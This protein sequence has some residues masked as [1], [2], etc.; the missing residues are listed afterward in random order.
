MIIP[1]QSVNP[2]TLEAIIESFVLREGTD[3][4]EQEKS[5]P[6]KVD[7]VKRRLKNGEAVL[8]WSELHETVNIMMKAQF[9]D[10]IEEQP[11]PEY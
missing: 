10:G 9:K 6:Q 2:D 8:V 4:G 7:D 1:W 5:L 11:Y 3:Y